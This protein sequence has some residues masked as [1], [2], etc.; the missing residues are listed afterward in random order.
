LIPKGTA[1]LQIDIISPV[2]AAGWFGP[3]EWHFKSE[4][5]DVALDGT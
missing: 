3:R 1:T 2:A 4:S 5:F